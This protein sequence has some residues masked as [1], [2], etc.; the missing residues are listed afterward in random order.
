MVYNFITRMLYKHS[1]SALTLV[2]ITLDLLHTLYII[3]DFFLV[4]IHKFN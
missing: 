4:F 3:F 1:Y 2:L